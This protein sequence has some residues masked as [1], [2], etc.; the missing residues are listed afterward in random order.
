MRPETEPFKQDVYEV[1][2]AI[3]YGKVLTYGE[4]ARLVGWPDHSRLVGRVMRGAS[5]ELGLPCHRVVN[6]Q[7]R[8]A[9][10]WQAQRALLEKEGVKIKATGC[11]DMSVS[12]WDVNHCI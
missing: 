3:P 11:V 2:G 6:S 7:G 5:A 12:L 8:L 10:G 1:V 4:I 9:P